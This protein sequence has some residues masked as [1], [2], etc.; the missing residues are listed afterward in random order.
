LQ[1]NARARGD[2]E[3][4][5]ALRSPDCFIEKADQ[6]FRLANSSREIASEL[7]A[8]A[9]QFMAKAVEMDTARDKEGTEASEAKPKQSD[10]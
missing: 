1:I 10:H 5:M 3:M 6:C 8:L 2:S 9:Q 4:A 7:E